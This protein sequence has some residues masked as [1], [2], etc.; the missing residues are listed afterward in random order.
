VLGLSPL[1][2]GL[3]SLPSAIGFIVGSNLAPKVIHRFRPAFVLGASLALAAVGLGLLLLVGASS[4]LAVIVAASLVISLA[5]SPMFNLTT[6][7][8]VGSAPPER[9]GAA[10]GISETGAEFGGALGISILGSI[11]TA[12]YRSELAK[13]LPPG[14]P[15]D[16]A[17]VARDTLGG[18]VGVATQLPDQMGLALLDVARSAFVQ[19]LHLVAGISA[20]VAVAAAIIAV[21]VFRGVPANS[22]LDEQ[23]DLGASNAAIVDL[24]KQ[25]VGNAA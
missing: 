15:S 10:S 4:G 6:E 11:G 13:G 21:L 18:A 1:E 9:S 16:A 5:L 20:V 25:K 8:I 23:S 19:G 7:L 3:W 22:Q 12:V 14:V 17:E 2:A 24:D